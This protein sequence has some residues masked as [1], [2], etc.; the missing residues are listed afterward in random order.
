ME[1]R[2]SKRQRNDPGSST[3]LPFKRIRHNLPS[4]SRQNYL[5]SNAETEKESSIRLCGSLPDEYSSSGDGSSTDDDFTSSA[6][7]PSSSSSSS[8]LSSS[9]SESERD[10][11]SISQE[12]LEGE[13]QSS[14]HRL[15]GSSL[16]SVP[17]PLRP[18]I[19]HINGSNLLSEVS[20]FLPKL[21]A[22]NQ[23]VQKDIAAGKAVILDSAGVEKD[24][25]QYIEMNLGLGV[26]EEKRNGDNTESENES[27]SEESS[28]SASDA[29]IRLHE[30][31]K[32]TDVLRRLMGNKSKPKKPGIEEVDDSSKKE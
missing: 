32:V 11:D 23:E 25:G 30:K 28:L 24:N 29:K 20:S 8:A 14:P 5:T 17:A 7:S 15:N 19:R 4:G 16:I 1:R 27:N 2:G 9:D 10:G 18:Q 6:G 31:R 26:L 3:D 21:K 22:A 12:G 13:V